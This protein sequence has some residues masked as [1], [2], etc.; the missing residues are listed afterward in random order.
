MTISS[1]TDRE[2]DCPDPPV[3]PVDPPDGQ[4]SGD[5]VGPG[6]PD[7]HGSGGGSNG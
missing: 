7:P 5:H 4:G 1:E 2:R 6:P 3:Q